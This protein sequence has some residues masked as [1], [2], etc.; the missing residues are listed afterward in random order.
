MLI[1]YNF[2]LC[3]FFCEFTDALEPRVQY[4]GTTVVVPNIEDG[5]QL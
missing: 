5:W 3:P 4:R 2:T 1:V